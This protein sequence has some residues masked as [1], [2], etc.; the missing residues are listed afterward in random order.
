VTGAVG[1]PTTDAYFAE[2][3][4]VDDPWEQAARWSELRKFDLTVACLPEP[5]YGRAFEPGCGTGLLTERLARRCGSVLASDRHERAVAV[6][7]RRCRGL[8][9]VTVRTGRLPTEWPEGSFD[10][11]VLSEVLY[12]LDDRGIDE[13][14][15]RTAA[16]LCPGGDLVAVHFRPEVPEHACRGDHVHARIRAFAGWDRLAHHLEDTFVL[17]AFRRR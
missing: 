8:A 12:Y 16:S 14:L 7:G 15:R 9:N 4:S 13:A 10:L 17:E 6:A 3:W 11:V 2:R 1:T 5:R